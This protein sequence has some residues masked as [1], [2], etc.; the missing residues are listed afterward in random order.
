[1]IDS[2][3]R[4]IDYVRLSVTDR[5]NLRC[6]YCMPECGVEQMSHMQVMRFEEMLRLCRVLSGMGVKKFKVSGGEPLVRR[7][8]CD[9]IADLKMLPGVEQ[10]TLTTN[11]VL[12]RQNLEQLKRSGI[13]GINISLD[14][15]NEFTFRELTRI[16]DIDS[17]L[18][19]LQAAL[20][21]K[22]CPIKI[23]AL[24]LKGKNDGELETL[25]ALARDMELSVRFIELMPI[26]L[27]TVY[28]PVSGEEVLRRLTAAYGEPEEYDRPMGNGPAKYYSF[29]G[30]KGKIGLINA[31]SH[32]F[33]S[34]CNRVRMTSDGWLK[35]CLQYDI[36][37]D[38]L[39]PLRRG[40][41][42]A[43]LQELV[44]QAVAQ[45]PEKHGFDKERGQIDNREI[46]N[47]NSIGG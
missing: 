30:F 11:G 41:S 28:E 5:C 21:A 47:M 39:T 44:A 10:V 35:L 34:S 26:G 4:T 7:G 38:L 12:L 15:L 3:G 23:N 2:F 8:V 1:M 31:I 13:D 42:D 46:K 20:A 24:L 25:A 22:I 43:E 33:C 16:G 17:V 29:P 14:T 19:G 9:F 18:D 40:A 37:V 32:A 27:G 45:K 36:G 6:L